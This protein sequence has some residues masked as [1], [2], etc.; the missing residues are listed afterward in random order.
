MAHYQ[1]IARKYRP[2]TFDEVVGQEA[3]A[4]TLRNAIEADRVAHAYMFCGPRGVGKTSMARILARALNCLATSKPTPEP[5]GECGLCVAAAVGEDLDVF[6]MDAASNRKVDDARNLIS[7]VS[8][9]PARARFKV[10]IVD[11]VHMLTTEAFNALLKTLE[12]PPPHVKFIFATTDPQKVPATIL[13]RC[14]RFDFRPVPPASITALLRRICE[15][16]GVAAEED[17]LIAVARA[18]DGGVRDAESLLEQL[19]TLGRGAVR[20]EDLHSLLGTVS[21]VRMRTLF[22]AVS[23]G[24]VAQALAVTSEVLDAGTD[25]GE[26]LRQCMRHAHD[27][28]LIKVQGVRAAGVVADPDSRRALEAQAERLSDA[29]LA[30]SVTLFSEALKNARLL[31]EGR[32]F[33]ETALARLAG[34]REMRYLDQIVRDLAALEKRIGAAPHGPTAAA[35][36]AAVAAP[37]D[38]AP[39]IPTPALPAPTAPDPTVSHP[40]APVDVGSAP[41]SAPDPVASRSVSSEHVAE[42]PAPSSAYRAS[43]TKPGALSGTVSGSREQSAPAARDAGVAALSARAVVDDVAAPE[44]APATEPATPPPPP[45]EL[46]AG[47]MR[48]RWGDVREAAR[49]ASSR[50]MAHL[51]PA[52]VESVEGDTLVLSFPRSSSFHRS[53]LDGAELREAFH[54]ALESVLGRRMRVRTTERDDH[55]DDEPGHGNAEEAPRDLVRDR[56]SAA[57]VEAA[58]NAPLTKLAESE[59]GARIVH[60]ERET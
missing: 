40:T 5:C 19:T 16:E 6:E 37:A 3:V 26:L 57:E 50:L 23:A 56:L 17:A 44:I 11:E 49:Q 24:D 18:S 43:A 60:L 13:S 8:F 20:L 38:P 4:L 14:Q 7:N 34:H 55:P 52:Q 9:H 10:Y 2:R 33:A 51:Q 31:G 30:Y 32:L 54:D 46:D 35:P 21:G 28:L 25:P 42:T 53:A 48:A 36:V 27:L 15:T 41:P 22:D 58:R 1:V 12:E 47:G 45:Q 59:L 29:T 39:T